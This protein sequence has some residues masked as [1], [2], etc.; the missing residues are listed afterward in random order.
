MPVPKVHTKRLFVEKLFRLP[1]PIL[2]PVP[3]SICTFQIVQ[4]HPRCH[5]FHYIIW[6][7]HAVNLERFPFICRHL[8]TINR[9]HLLPFKV[10]VNF[11]ARY[12]IWPI[13]SL[14]DHCSSIHASIFQFNK[15]LCYTKP[16]IK[17]YILS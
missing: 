11:I 8:Q 17:H 7:L 1:N 9:S 15:P 3:L 14:L 12:I 4:C 2:L 5:Q 6:F 10:L 16:T 13:L